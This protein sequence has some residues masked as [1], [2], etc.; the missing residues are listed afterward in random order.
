VALRRPLGW[1]AVAALSIAAGIA[2]GG[3]GWAADHGP[4]LLQ[5]TSAAAGVWLVGAFG[6]GALA[7]DRVRAAAGG[8]VAIVV[9]VGTY[10]V[11]FHFVSGL[12]DLRYGV[13]VGVAWALGG[14]GVGAVLGWAGDAWRRGGAPLGVAVLAG[15]LAGEAMLLM[16]AW[17]SHGARLMLAGELAAGAVLPF[18]LAR[19]HLAQAVV[20]TVAVALVVVGLESELRGAMRA[21]GWRG[22]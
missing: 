18:A 6:V 7:G 15:A 3:F 20:L 21:V 17:H 13:V 14:V 12:V 9:G 10:Y 22:A 1:P 5:W 2:V 8:A 11:L 19:R 16:G 4:R